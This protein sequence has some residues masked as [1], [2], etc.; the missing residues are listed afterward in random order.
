ME[1]L[2]KLSTIAYSGFTIGMKHT[3]NNLFATTTFE[4][5]LTT[6]FNASFTSAVGTNTI[7]L[8]TPFTWDGTSNILVDMCYD[9][10]SAT[11][12]DQVRSS[13]VATAMAVWNS[14]TSGTGCTLAACR[15]D[16]YG[17]CTRSTRSQP[18]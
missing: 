5:G 4:T 9:N 14:A 16:R 2:Q 1:V 17:S 7:T 18:H 15:L 11:N 3:T 13:T 12:N 6:V 8:T 10:A